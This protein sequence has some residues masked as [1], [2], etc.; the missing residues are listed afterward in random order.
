VLAASFFDW[1]GSPP[2]THFSKT[3]ISYLFVPTRK[4][5]RAL[6]PTSPLLVINGEAK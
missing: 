5:S 2:Y 1:I 6:A 4:N 3:N